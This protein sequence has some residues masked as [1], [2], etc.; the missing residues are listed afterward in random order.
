CRRSAAVAPSPGLISDGRKAKKP[1]AAVISFSVTSETFSWVRS[2]PFSVSGSHLVVLD[3]HLCMVRDLLRRWPS[4]LEIWKLEDYSSGDFVG[5][6]AVKVIGSFGDS[7]PSEKIIIATS[8]HKV[9]TY[10]TMSR[11][12]ETIHST[13]ETE[14]CH[15]IEPCDIRFSLFRETLVPVYRTKE[16]I[17]LSSP[18]AKVTKEILLRLPAKSALNFKFV[19]QKW[20]SLIRSDSF[21]HAYFLHKNVD[22]RPKIMLVG[23]LTGEKGFSSIPLDKW[24]QQAS[25]D[26]GALLDTKKYRNQGLMLHQDLE[27]HVNPVEPDHHPFAVGNKNVGLGFNPLTQEHVI[28]EMFYHIKDYQSRRYYLSCSVT[29]CDSRNVQQ[30][31]PP[32]LPV[33]DMPSA[34]LEGM[35]YWMSEP[36]LGL[37]HERAIVSFNI[38]T[39]MFDVIPCPSR[40]ARSWDSQSPRRAFVAE[41]EGVLCA[42]LAN[43]VRDELCMWTWEHGQWDRSYTIYLK[44]CLDYS[45]GTNIVVPWAIDPTDGRI[46]LNTGR[47]LGFYDP[48]KREVENYI[49][50]DQVPLLK[51]KEQTLCPGAGDQMP[52]DQPSS[53][54][55][56]PGKNLSHSIDRSEELNGMSCNLS[57]L[58]P[59][60]YEES[61]AYY[62]TPGRARILQALPI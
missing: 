21:C 12:L 27:R 19:C 58:V 61:L 16:E 18:M 59:M 31:P 25:D 29:D 50:L 26:Q 48:L 15:R 34:Y 9:S 3:G 52:L 14:T 42:V 36:R 17:A 33:N 60:L 35:L 22:R 54:S 57:P 43:P 56:S 10:D 7:K 41:L 2:P 39:R 6:K 47:R 30:L 45:L 24:L 4:M 44:S 55:T 32:P 1:R 62:R 53:S 51:W 8:R 40:I 13:M 28:V 46:L 38:A 20:H 37:N 23:K 11:T 49:A 5:S